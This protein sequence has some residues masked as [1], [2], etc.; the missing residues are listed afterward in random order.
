MRVKHRSYKKFIQES[1]EDIFSKQI[2]LRDQT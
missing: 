1:Q 2:F